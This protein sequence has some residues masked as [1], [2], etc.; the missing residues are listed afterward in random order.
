MKER[1]Y[2]WLAQA[3]SSG[4]GMASPRLERS[5]SLADAFEPW[6]AQGQSLGDLELE[7][8]LGMGGAGE[9]WRAFNRFTNQRLAV[10]V[11]A[12]PAWHQQL[13]T[14]A[15]ALG[16][17]MD[18]ARHRS[19]PDSIVR[20]FETHL[21]HD[22]PYLVMEYMSGGDLR[23]LLRRKGKLSQPE[24]IAILARV[25][26]ALDH[27]HQQGLT[28]R[29]I[30]P[31]NILLDEDGRAKVT[32]FGL[33]RI[34]ADSMLSIHR[35]LSSRR[36]SSRFDV[37]GT[38]DYMAPEQME[39][40][41]CSA[42]TDIYSVGVVLYEMLIGQRPRGLTSPTR[43][44]SDLNPAWDDIFARCYAQDPAE[45]Y[46]SIVE[47]R[48]DLER[49]F[50]DL[51]PRTPAFV[52]SASTSEASNLGAASATGTQSLVNPDEEEEARSRIGAGHVVFGFVVPT[53]VW[54]VL[55]A[56]HP[57]SALDTN[58]GGIGIAGAGVYSFLLFNL[59]VFWREW[60]P[61]LRAM[62]AT[63]VLMLTPA[64]MFL[65]SMFIAQ[66]GAVGAT[67]LA[68]LVHTVLLGDVTAK[69][70][71]RKGLFSPRRLDDVPQAA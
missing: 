29:D 30:K 20:L 38:V 46:Q 67:I 26:E 71:G 41:E 62:L 9:V 51:M 24:T 68:S 47:F 31:E 4:G 13:L 50:G 28:H 16:Q 2:H 63:S 15:Q 42:A 12:D 59:F 33:G 36:F 25:V 17:L 53:V 40:R 66:S 35:S 6:M 18:A 52:P 34:V 8:L 65:V 11:C 5:D 69:A 32:D 48:G 54:I 21:A 14:E 7:T 58:I 22:P 44:R 60:K 43:R 27:A 45:R 19:F 39:G 3:G 57:F 61:K 56:T 70:N 10:K 23:S 1:R 55:I 37:S 64:M 49:H